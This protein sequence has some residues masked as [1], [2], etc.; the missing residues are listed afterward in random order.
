MLSWIGPTQ[1]GRTAVVQLCL[2]AAAT[3]V[4]VVGGASLIVTVVLIGTGVLMLLQQ[5]A[6]GVLP[7]A[8]LLLGTSRWE[9]VRLLGRLQRGVYPYRV[10]CLLEPTA[11]EKQRHS[12]LYWNHFQTANIRQLRPDTWRDVVFGVMQHVAHIVIDTRILTD[13]VTEERQRISELGFLDRTIFI[14]DSGDKS[15]NVG[16][17]DAPIPTG[18]TMN[19]VSPGSLLEELAKK[20]LKSES[21]PANNPLVGGIEFLQAD[22]ATAKQMKKV[23]EAGGPLRELIRDCAR[24]GH[25]EL[26]LDAQALLKLLEGETNGAIEVYKTLGRDISAVEEFL[27]KWGAASDQ[28]AQRLIASLRRVYKQLCLLQ[29][30]VD[31]AYPGYVEDMISHLER[32]EADDDQTID[33]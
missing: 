16:G 32:S 2:V 21:A 5:I 28:P 7:P 30:A 9:T 31:R 23:S 4:V 22:V 10:V 1:I 12:P 33:P 24:Y 13:C 17:L 27:D 20:G 15:T 3:F 29:R 14:S 19:I 6:S 26:V 8:I 25:G 11:V 18:Q